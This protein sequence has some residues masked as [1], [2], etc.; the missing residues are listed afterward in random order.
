[1][2]SYLKPR[3]FAP[4]LIPEDFPNLFGPWMMSGNCVAAHA[5]TT[6][7][8]LQS[9]SEDKP[10]FGSLSRVVFEMIIGFSMGCAVEFLFVRGTFG[11]LVNVGRSL[12]ADE[13]FSRS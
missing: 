4:Y 12:N 1:M 13:M 3:H 5:N 8:P 11:A 6:W 9:G 2:S 7:N 10:R